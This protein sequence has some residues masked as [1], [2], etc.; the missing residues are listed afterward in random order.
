MDADPEAAISRV[1]I[2]AATRSD[3]AI[4]IFFISFSF[5][6]SGADE[7]TCSGH[8]ALSISNPELVV[9]L[10]GGVSPG[11]RLVRRD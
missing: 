10:D 5:I 8:I 6:A 11:R 1:G 7:S 2:T 3:L 4:F 9:P